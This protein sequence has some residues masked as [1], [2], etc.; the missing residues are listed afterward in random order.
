MRSWDQQLQDCC[1]SKGTRLCKHRVIGREASRC[2]RRAQAAPGTFAQGSSALPFLLG[3][4]RWGESPTARFS[5]KLQ[6]SSVL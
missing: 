6:G 3:L 4:T 1:G 5:L 2:D